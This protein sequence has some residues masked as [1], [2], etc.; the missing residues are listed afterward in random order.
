MTSLTQ[1][2]RQT[3]QAGMTLLELLISMSIGLIILAG[4]GYSYLAARN[5]FREQDALSRMQEGARLAFDVVSKDIHMAGFTGCSST[6]STANSPANAAAEWYQYFDNNT[7]TSNLTKT[8][9]LTGYENSNE[10]TIAFNSTSNYKSTFPADANFKTNVAGVTG[11]VSQGDVLLVKHVDPSQQYIVT[12]GAPANPL[13]LNTTNNF[14][15][16]QILIGANCF[17]GT[18]GIEIFKDSCTTSTC[19]GNKLAYTSTNALATTVTNSVVYPLSANV[20]FICR[21]KTDPTLTWT[22]P[23]GYACTNNTDP[24]LYRVSLAADGTLSTQE[25]VEGVQDMQLSYLVIKSGDTTFTPQCYAN[26]SDITNNTVKCNGT[27]ITT[28]WNSILGVRISL[29]MVSRSTE[30][31]ITT[32]AQP[33]QLDTNGDGVINTSDTP[34]EKVTPTDNQLRKVFTTTV[35]VKN[36]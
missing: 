33:F 23:T 26:A 16:G 11:F 24:A 7:N 32:E 15:N 29:L 2:R 31:N 20:Y 28:D 34:L 4:L 13:V 8:Y 14:K 9:F 12:T 19:T 36:Y 22:T 17:S 35:M 30:A 18:A 25:L 6:L 27:S 1:R 10:A 21:P 5:T 3:P